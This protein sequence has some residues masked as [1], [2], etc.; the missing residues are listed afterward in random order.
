MFDGV[1]VDLPAR[2]QRLLA[3]LALRDRPLLRV[4][5]AGTLWIDLSEPR[6][7][8]TLRAAIWRLRQ[9]GDA[10]VLATPSHVALGDGIDVDV[11]HAVAAS[12]NALD[13]PDASYL[14]D[15]SIAGELLP[16]WYDDWV[17]SERELLRQLRLHALEAVADHLFEHEQYGKAVEACLLAVQADPLRESAH[18][19]L[20]RIY[21]AEGNACDAVR[22]Y[23]LYAE[24]L[25]QELGL[26]PS[27]QLRELASATL[28]P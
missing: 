27:R 17:A 25:R 4:Y 3:Y 20:I 11:R 21:L 22:Q 10:L 23:R 16:D 15:G 12:R 26:Q 1:L 2:S 7:L 18:S 14:R 8:A 24:R 6:S 9:Y 13:R 19:R 28:D 5:A